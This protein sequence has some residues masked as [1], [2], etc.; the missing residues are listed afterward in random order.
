MNNDKKHLL[1]VDDERLVLATLA[2]G[3]TNAGY[4]VSSAESMSEAEA[5]LAGG[6]KFDLAILDVRMPGRGGLELAERL[7]RL[8]HIPF[9]LLTAYND[10][11][12]VDRATACGA[13]G[14]LVKPVDV[15]QLVPAIEAALARAQEIHRLQSTERQLQ[16]ALDSD[17][18]ISVAIGIT[19][20]QHR[21]DRKGAFD[22]LRKT[23]RSQRCKLVELASKVIRANEPLNLMADK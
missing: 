10:Q 13:L 17:R 21:L 12:L 8:D 5:L 11:P 1:L 15:P 6:E 7:H 19:M 22:L 9:I 3:L 16:T 4:N 14:Y 23:A 2:M 20:V 18:D